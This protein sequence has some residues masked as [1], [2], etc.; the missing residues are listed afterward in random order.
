[1]SPWL[2]CERL[3][4][5]RQFLF[6][7]AQPRPVDGKRLRHIHQLRGAAADCCPGGDVCP[8][9]HAEARRVDMRNHMYAWQGAMW[10]GSVGL[11]R[12]TLLPM[13]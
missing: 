8:H 6:P 4:T 2:Y 1:V 5:P 3:V 12:P 7:R 10:L 9:V 11:V 13:L